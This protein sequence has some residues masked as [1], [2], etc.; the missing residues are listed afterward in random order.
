MLMIWAIYQLL[1]LHENVCRRNP[2]STIREVTT[3]KNCA[4]SYDINPR[5][6]Q[7]IR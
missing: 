5:L 4:I 6:K 2:L 1:G 3:N 7:D